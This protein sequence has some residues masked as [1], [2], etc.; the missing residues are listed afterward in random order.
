MELEQ[1]LAIPHIDMTDK[2]LVAILHR[3]YKKCVVKLLDLK[4]KYTLEMDAETALAFYI[5][6]NDEKFNPA[7]FTDITLKTICN[8]I[9]QKYA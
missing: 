2:L 8:S 4:K 3:L 7:N 5:Y 1:V 6:F 9:N